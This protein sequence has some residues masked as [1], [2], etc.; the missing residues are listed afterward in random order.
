M[1]QVRI[2]LV[3]DQYHDYDDARAIMQ[4]GIS[5]WEEIS[6]VD[7]KLLQANWWQLTKHLNLANARPV[8][9]EKDSVPVSHRIDS[10]KNWID[11][12]RARQEQEQAAK[13][14]KAEERARKKLL[15]D[16]ES[17]LKLLAELKKKY[18]TE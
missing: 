18:P 5:D 14:A 9:L 13:R 3:H 17:E 15:K 10:I 7:F 16:A 8:L 12:E 1:R 2:V 4:E 11:R 6:E